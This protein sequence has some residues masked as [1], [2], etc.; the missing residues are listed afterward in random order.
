MER[1]SKMHTG[2]TWTLDAKD[3]HD[4]GSEL[5]GPEHHG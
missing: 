4:V 1:L 2:G 5:A 3:E